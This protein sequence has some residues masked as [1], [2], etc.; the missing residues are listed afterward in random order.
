MTLPT[1]TVLLEDDAGSFSIDVSSRVLSVNGY[2][3]SRGRD[4][5][6]GAVTAGELTNLTLNNSDGFFS[7]S[8]SGWDTDGWDTGPWG[9][10]PLMSVDQRIQL[11][12]TVNGVT[13]I[14]FTG[15]VKAM[16]VA[17][18]ATV[19]TFSTVQPTAT[20]VQARLERRTMRSMLEEEI[21]ER[22]PSAYY[23]LGEAEGATTAGDTS[24]DQAPSL[25][26]VGTG[27]PVAFGQGT[28]PTDGMTTATFAGGQ[29]L[30]NDLTPGPSYSELV[31]F[32]RSGAPSSQEVLEC[33]AH[34][35][36]V[37]ETTGHVSLYHS[38]PAFLAVAVATS[39]TSVCD[40][41]VHMAGWTVSAGV[42]YGLIVDGTL[43]SIADTSAGTSAASVSGLNVGGAIPPVFPGGP[44]ALTGN[45][46]HVAHF[47]GRVLSAF[48]ASSIWGVISAAES[49]HDRMQ[50]FAGYTGAVVNTLGLSEDLVTPQAA[51]GGSIWDAMQDVAT[52]E[53]GLL[54][55]QSD[56][57]LLLAGRAFVAG[58]TAPDLILSSQWV[59]PDIQPVLD[60]QRLVNYFETTAQ[61]TGA[62]QI[63]R[64]ATSEATH[65]RYP[66]TQTYLVQ[67]DNEALQRANWA[68]TKLA[69]SA[70]RYG[71]LT[72]N[73]FGMTPALAS[74][75]LAALDIT[76][77]LRVTS[78][79]SQDPGGITADVVVEG[80][81]E[82][83]TADSWT[84]TCNVVDRSLFTALILDDPV[85]GVLDAYPILN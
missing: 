9:G 73:L 46:S 6:Q 69:E 4:D 3:I 75:V 70:P 34:E 76:R 15:Y 44:V 59:T 47:D 35:Y 38:P 25:T 22:N 83:V 72:I 51:S 78:L 39:T 16:P 55:G 48:D 31:F 41:D 66:Q 27:T 81:S 61:G 67:T 84:I 7:D 1:P 23:T 52:T 64:D 32:S 58:K 56:G 13:H 42:G 11:Q 80:W 62:T 65:G 79:A 12:E 54:V 63:V 36:L 74:S 2:Q 14:R 45:V 71:T 24:G 33:T 5:W 29:T 26:M 10:A 43:A 28:G 17:W 57:S 21:L 30:A 77:W 8:G 50:R 18:P 82:Q 20:D 68:V 19:V 85:F 53:G 40:G 37:L 60:D 49:V